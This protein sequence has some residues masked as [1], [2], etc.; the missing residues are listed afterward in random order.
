[1]KFLSMRTVLLAASAAILAACGGGGG[2]GGGSSGSAATG[3]TLVISSANAKPA[4]ADGLDASTNLGAASTGADFATGVQVQATP[5]AQPVQLSS[6]GLQLARRSL[7][8]PA[9]AT[10]VSLNST[11]ACALGGTLTVSGNVAN[12]GRLAAGDAMTF[13][14]NGCAETVD[15]VLAMMSG[16]MAISVLSGSFTDP[17]PSYPQQI[18]MTLVTTNFGVTSA[19]TTT[20]ANGDLRI[21]L[22]QTSATSSTTILTG[23]SLANSYSR[24]GS[25]RS[26]TVQN[27]RMEET[28]TGNSSSTTMSATVTTNN[29]RLGSSSVTYQLTTP[30]PVVVTGVAVASGSVRVQGAS[31]ALLLTAV[32]PDTF[33]LQV[34]ANGDGNYETNMSTTDGELQS[35]L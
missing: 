28:A 21:D 4:S 19:G 30:T 27:F 20:I 33:T 22:R 14:A 18:V 6:V 16:V 34:D 11:L 7:G 12:P 17:V 23:S 8:L 35:L 24:P 10:G 32:A 2:D 9:L 29:P 13:T 31:S 3:S 15:G 26:V 1:M 5:G 25:T